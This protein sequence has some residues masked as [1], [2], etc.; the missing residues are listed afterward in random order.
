MPAR[1]SLW[2]ALL[3]VLA[4]AAAA[5]WVTQVRARGAAGV[6]LS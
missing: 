5:D 3:L 6:G 4:R 1:G 2:A